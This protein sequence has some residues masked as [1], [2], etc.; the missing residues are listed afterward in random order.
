V[1]SVESGG[2]QKLSESRVESLAEAQR[3]AL[4]LMTVRRKLICGTIVLLGV[5]TIPL[6]IFEWHHYRTYG[7][8]VSYG[9]HVDA[10]NEDFSIAI[11]GQTKLYWAELSNYSLSTLRLPGCRPMSDILS[12]PV[13]Y[14]Y[15][16]QRF[17]VASNTWQ[18]IMDETEHGWCLYPPTTERGPVETSLSPGSSVRVMGSEATGAR[19][20]FRNGDL[21]RFIVFRNVGARGDWKTAL[22]SAP[23]R[24][25]DDVVRDEN[26]SFR[27]KH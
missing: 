15:A 12:P 10:L 27:V 23:F 16:V 7:H 11:P 1:D 2:Y 13:E 26:N 5:S 17:D 21:A 8:F 18:T 20:P 6:I 4:S 24:I 25:E 22:A 9:L 19:E 14:P 3:S